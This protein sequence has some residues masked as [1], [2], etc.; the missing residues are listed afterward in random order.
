MK[1]LLSL[2]RIACDSAVKAGADQADVFVQEVRSVSV[3]VEKSLIKSCNIIHDYGLSIRAF[4]NGGMGFSFTMS[5]KDEDAVETSKLAAALARTAQPDPD[6]KTLPEPRE[7]KRVAGLYDGGVEALGVEKAVE[8]A[9]LGIDAAKSVTEDIV[10]MGGAGVSVERHALVNSLGVAVEDQMTSVGMGIFAIVKRG[11]DVGSYMEFDSARR[12]RDFQPEPVGRKAAEEAVRF[13]GAKKVETATLPVVFG[14]LASNTIFA[15]TCGAANAESVQRNRS[16]L[17][18]MKGRSVASEHVT[19]IDNGLFR[20]GMASA[21][22]DGEGVPRRETAIVENGVLKTYLHNS[23]TSGKAGEEN[24]GHAARWSYRGG[25]GIGPTNLRP[26]LGDWGRDE[27][28]EETR[29]GVYVNMAA[30]SPNTVTGDISGTIDFGFKIENGELAFPVKN[31]MLGVN[32]VD[33]L[34]SIDAVSK[35]Y[36]EEPGTIMPTV[37]AL[38]VRIAGGR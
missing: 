3:S 37:R 32:M 38:N 34:R 33:L 28:I 14:P 9:M 17:V 18:G 27:I 35:D 29:E 20:A 24:T 4:R 1:D 13:L 16:F 22:Y 2:G 15:S 6:F 36:R 8:W 7:G 31:T 23:Y 10:T 21:P 12:L 30:L 26:K 19:I 25:V 11:S 5:L